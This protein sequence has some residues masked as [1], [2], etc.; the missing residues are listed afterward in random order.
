[1]I[2]VLLYHNMIY[3]IHTHCI[4]MIIL[5]FLIQ[6]TCTI[7]IMLLIFIMLYNNFTFTNR[8]LAYKDNCN[9]INLISICIKRRPSLYILY[10]KPYYQKY[11]Y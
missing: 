5:F 7:Y 11:H 9:F 10:I 3:I 2:T 6:Y 1:M 4:V 8:Y